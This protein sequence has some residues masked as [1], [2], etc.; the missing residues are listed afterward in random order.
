MRL[1]LLAATLLFTLTASAQMPL[2]ALKDQ[3][4]VLLVFSPSSA[5]RRF[6]LQLSN[7]NA[8]DM[9]T[10]DLVLIPVLG[11]WDKADASLRSSHAPYTD[12]AQQNAVRTQFHMDRNTF[13]V[14]LLGK[15]GGEKLRR[16]IPIA[17]P[18]LNQTIDSMPMRQQ[19]QKTHATP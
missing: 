15:D 5:D 14:L 3:K 2:Q 17:M 16:N 10:R 9:A 18:E 11:T 7:L 8:N 13:T 1:P 12:D 6:K 19:E 4:R